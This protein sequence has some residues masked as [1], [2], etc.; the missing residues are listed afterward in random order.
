MM[1]ALLLVAGCAGS[2]GKAGPQASPGELYASGQYA[3]AYEAATQQATT[4]S[5]ARR[6]DAALLAGLSAQA[7]NRSS[8][9]TQWLTPLSSMKD[10]LLSGKALAALG[11][12]SQEQGDHPSAAKRLL[13]AGERLTG[14][15]GA[16][17][18][19]YAGDSLRAVNDMAGATAA[20]E[21]A[22]DQVIADQALRVMIGDRLRGMAPPLKTAGTV[23][24]AQHSVVPSTLT[25]QVGAFRDLGTAQRQ[26]QRAANSARV[27]VR[28]V[29]ILK[30]GE[31]LYA[32]RVGRFSSRE[33]AER[34]KGVVGGTASV[35]VA[36]GE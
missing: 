16:R 18:N 24:P 26:A 14:D 7:L 12:L 33:A 35:T 21:R 29:P 5:G 4:L 2:G 23:I 15:E 36:S 22:Q 28:I 6:D 10:P 32:V 27:D 11:I 1:L 20:W 34:V 19:L 13:A 3:Q 9:A 17:A 25:V 30:N 8:E 31:R